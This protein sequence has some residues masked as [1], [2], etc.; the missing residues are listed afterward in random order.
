MDP[1]EQAIKDALTCCFPKIAL[2]YNYGDS[3][4]AW[5][6]AVKAI[7]GALGQQNN[8][9][10]WSHFRK[11]GNYSSDEIKQHVQQALGLPVPDYRTE[12]L[13]DIVWWQQDQDADVINIPLVVESEW[14]T[15]ANNVKDDF[16]KLLLAR[17][18]YRVMIFECNPKV[19]DWFK[20]Q[21]SKYQCTQLGDRYL[22]CAWRANYNRF[23][24]ESYIVP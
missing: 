17:S 7:F 11:G 21:I 13:N 8:C 14:G 18:K 19:I 23:D 20:I 5:T 22:F 9:Y 2:A 3:N 6:N 15:N 1:I 16:Q 4:A 10:V 12:W 24:F